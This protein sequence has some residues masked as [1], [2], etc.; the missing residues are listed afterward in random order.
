MAFLADAGD[1]AGYGLRYRASQG[2]EVGRDGC[3]EVTLDAATG[4]I[5]IGGACAMG[6]RGELQL[7]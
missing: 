6:I 3:I 1:P 7:G 4:A 5:S 2:R